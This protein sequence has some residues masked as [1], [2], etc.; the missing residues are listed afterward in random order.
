[1]SYL[2]VWAVT[3]EQVGLMWNE[4]VMENRS[5]LHWDN[6]N[7]EDRD[8]YRENIRATIVDQN[9]MDTVREIVWNIASRHLGANTE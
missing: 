8:R 5:D 1:M 7:Q 6:L 2:I 9:V 3:D 4:D